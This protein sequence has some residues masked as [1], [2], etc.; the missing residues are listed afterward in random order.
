[1]NKT[2]LV[3]E[4]FKPD[5]NGK[6][7]W[8]SKSDCVGKYESLK[9]V[10][11]NTWY[12]NKGLSHLIFEKDNLNGE[13]RWRFNGLIKNE[14]FNRGVRKDI[15]E[16]IRQQKCVFSNSK[17]TKGNY[18]EVDHK[19]GRY[20]EESVSDLKTQKKEDF[21]PL[22]RQFNLQKRSDCNKC[23][24]TNKRFDA[25]EMGYSISFS[26]GSEKYEGTCKG[27]FW[28][29]CLDFKSQLILK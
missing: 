2:K 7:E 27:C 19:N 10:H 15:W 25:K 22:L 1:M 17:G 28:F 29:D 6:S 20:N 5:E 21:Q 16:N 26:S 8:I 24:Q 13:D 12:R 9:P 18:I 14:L 3:L 23:K 11:G 4:L